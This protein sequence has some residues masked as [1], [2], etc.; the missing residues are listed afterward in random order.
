MKNIR[1]LLNG[2]IICGLA[3]AMASNLAAQTVSQGRAKVVRIKGFARFTTGNNVW[4]PLKVG[5]TL[6]PGS[7][8]QTGIEKGSFVDLVLGDGNAPV[9]AVG[10]ALTSSKAYY[11]P[12]AEQ[13]IVRVWEN[14]LLGID[15]LTSMETGADTVT[16]TQLDLQAGRIFGSVKK[17]SAASKYE[18]KIPSGVAGIRGTVY[19][20]SAE[21]RIRVAAGLVVLAFVGPD[22]QTI[23][24]QEVNAGYEYD[25]RANKVSPLPPS[26]VDTMLRLPRG[27]TEIGGAPLIRI[28]DQTLYRE[29]VSPTE[30][31][32]GE[33]NNNQGQNQP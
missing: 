21:G 8:I 13:N 23:T 27:V 11:Q 18:V 22:G 33:N 28:R 24:T 32:Q 15:K 6:R 3:L 25:A 20:I 7:V 2:L 16:E 14:S 31:E 29:R 30:D 12:S 5:E 9:S 1:S 10:P 26:E 19:E 4:Q 17:M